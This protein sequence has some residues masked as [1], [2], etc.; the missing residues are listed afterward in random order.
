MEK[1]VVMGVV[2]RNGRGLAKWAWFSEMGMVLHIRT[3]HLSR[4][5]FERPWTLVVG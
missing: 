5:V 2:P 4:W 3:I 1:G